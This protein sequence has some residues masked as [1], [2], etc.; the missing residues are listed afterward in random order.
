MRRRAPFA[1]G[2]FVCREI[3]YRQ[4]KACETMLFNLQ[5]VSVLLLN[6]NLASCFSMP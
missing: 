2:I 1:G 3:R 6:D 4:G 5:T